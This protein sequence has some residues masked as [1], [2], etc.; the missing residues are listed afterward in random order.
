M[1]GR[2]YVDHLVSDDRTP[3][4]EWETNHEQEDAGCVER[5]EGADNVDSPYEGEGESEEN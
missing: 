2:Q 5:G 4:D 3:E 1:S